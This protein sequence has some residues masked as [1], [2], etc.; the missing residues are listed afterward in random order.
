MKYR[1]QA[2]QRTDGGWRWFAEK[3]NGKDWS[4]VDDTMS[5]ESAEQAEEYLKLSIKLQPVTVKEFEFDFD[6]ISDRIAD[7]MMEAEDI[8]QEMR[9]TE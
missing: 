4:Y 6:P 8:K 9:K 5:H 2:E 1:I 3:W 7:G